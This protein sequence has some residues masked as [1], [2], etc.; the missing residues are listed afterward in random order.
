MCVRDLSLSDPL[1]WF[2]SL[3]DRLR[4]GV[5]N[6]AGLADHTESAEPR[7][8]VLTSILFMK[9]KQHLSPTASR[10]THFLRYF[11]STNA[12]LDALIYR[13]HV[14]RISVSSLPLSL[15]VHRLH[16]SSG[17]STLPCRRI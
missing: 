4:L 9:E 16:R 17:G 7:V 11:L 12:L 10:G 3:R 6:G 5:S 1:Q 15:L 14:K 8:C 13:Y 2:P